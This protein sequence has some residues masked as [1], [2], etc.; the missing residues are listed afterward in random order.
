MPFIIE[1]HKLWED[2]YLSMATD[3]QV[4]L[5][6]LSLLSI[7]AEHEIKKTLETKTADKMGV[8]YHLLQSSSGISVTWCGLQAALSSHHYISL[9]QLVI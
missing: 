7:V 4:Y 1:V 2:R 3:K 6:F 5:P 8:T 9:W